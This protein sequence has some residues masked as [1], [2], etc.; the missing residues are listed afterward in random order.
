MFCSDEAI[1]PVSAVAEKSMT[2]VGAQCVMWRTLPL[3]TLGVDRASLEDK[4][5]ARLHQMWLEWPWG[6][7]SSTDLLRHA[8]SAHRY[9]RG[10]WNGQ[11]W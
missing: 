9:G 6:G 3:A 10:A 11:R 2:Q 7:L 8:C 1:V 5:Q 4:S